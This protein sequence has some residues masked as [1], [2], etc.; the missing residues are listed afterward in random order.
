MLR[1]MKIMLALAV[2]AIV[3]PV[4]IVM[5]EGVFAV[6]AKYDIAAFWV[7]IPIL[8]LFVGIALAIDRAEGR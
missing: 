6:S 8:V 7:A 5:T 3:L 2:T 4:T 1:G